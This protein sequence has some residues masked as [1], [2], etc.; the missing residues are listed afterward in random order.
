MSLL[1]VLMLCVCGFACLALAMVRHQRD[2]LGRLL[3]PI[4]THG[5]RASGWLCLLLAAWRLIAAQGWSLGL[6][7]YSGCTSL[8]AGLVHLGLLL[9]ARRRSQR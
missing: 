6:V 9:H 2:L 5:L 3:S 8:A 1:P 7:S 4:P